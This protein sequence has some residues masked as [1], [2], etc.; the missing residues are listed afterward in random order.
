MA[1]PL[2]PPPPPLVPTSFP[3]P[4]S[5]NPII[6]PN[7]YPGLLPPT[8][9]CFGSFPSQPTIGWPL[10]H[11]QYPSKTFITPTPQTNPRITHTQPLPTLPHPKWVNMKKKKAGNH[12]TLGSRVCSF[13][14]GAKLFSFDYD[15]GRTAPYHII[16]KRGRFIGS[17]WL[18]L[19]SL[20][21]LINT[22]ELLRQAEDLKGFFRFLRTE[23]STLELSCLQNQKGRFVELCEYHGGAQRGGIRIPEGFRGKHWDRFVKELHS[24]FPD[25]AL[26]AKHHT[27]KSNHGQGE[28]N[29]EKR[30]SRD[31]L[32]ASVSESRF[33]IA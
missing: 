2:P 12:R 31:G 10:P 14:V 29:M 23:Y 21:W 33:E 1:L 15:G 3:P 9:P 5:S 17:L 20:Q 19:K 22:W 25:T 11:Y 7:H 8:P 30:D 27:G 13:R 18:G 26:P 24:F 6:P 16:E 32:K 28:P 4:P